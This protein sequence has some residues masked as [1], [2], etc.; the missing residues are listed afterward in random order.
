MENP[1]LR[2]K[3]GGAI[4]PWLLVCALLGLGGFGYWYG[5]RPIADELQKKEVELAKAQGELTHLQTAA[6]SA[7]A[8]LDKAQDDLKQAKADLQQSAQQK[9]ADAK[10]LEELKKQAGGGEVQGANGQI[11]VTMVD[12]V[13]F[14]SGEAELS[15]EGEKVLMGLGGVLKNADKLVEVAGH[16]DNQPVKSEVRELYPTNW[17]LSASRATNVC[18]YLQEV[19]GINP[20]RLKAAEYSSYRPVASNASEKGRA[21]NRRIEILL[22][23]NRIKTVKGDF[24]DEVAEKAPPPGKHVKGP[25]EKDRLKAMTALKQQKAAPTKTAKNDKKHH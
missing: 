14:K 4:V 17:E 15:P 23:P 18:R 13:L 20:R 19:V 5:H 7:K 12:K 6:N 9:D 3:K 1:D 10:L 24:S 16:A 22:L 2:S 25:T 21:K 8:D 11:T